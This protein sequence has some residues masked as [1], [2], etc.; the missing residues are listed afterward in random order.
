[1][2]AGPTDPSL[3]PDETGGGL[4]SGRRGLVIVAHPDDESLWT[5]GLI[6]LRNHWDW[7]VIAMCR[8]SDRDRRPRFFSALER[9]GAQGRIADLDDGPEQQPLSGAH[10]RSVLFDELDESAYDVVL[11]HS[12][13][14]EYTR[15]LRHEEVSRAVTG[16]WRTGEIVAP[17]LWLFAYS[18]DD[19]ASLPHPIGEAHLKFRLPPRVWLAKREIVERVY[20][21]GPGSWEHEAAPAEEAFWRFRSLAAFRKWQER[22]PVRG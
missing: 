5:G 11:T 19:G 20:G 1:M 7:T 8:G 13:E 12:P 21:F 16:L 18:D 15:H 6:M 4:D 17:E 9:L 3:E 10:V 2:S 14:G 22:R